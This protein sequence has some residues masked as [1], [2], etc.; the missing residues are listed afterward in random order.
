MLNY[1]RVTTVNGLLY[2]NLELGAHVALVFFVS[3]CYVDVI[4]NVGLD[5]S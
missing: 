4:A 3:T 2:T 1:Q 5:M